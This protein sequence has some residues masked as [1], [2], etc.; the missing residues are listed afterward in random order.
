MYPYNGER[1]RVYGG[2]GILRLE[3]SSKRRYALRALIHL[4]QTGKRVTVD[5]ISAEANI[6]RRLLARILA[7]LSHA[8]LV[9]SQEGAVAAPAW[10][11][12]RKR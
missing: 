10:P 11:G 9:E 3:L 2:V 4:S 1:E 12:R 6:P 8:G 5:R 7:D